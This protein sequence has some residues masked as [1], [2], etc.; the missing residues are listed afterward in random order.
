MVKFV[1]EDIGVAEAH[2]PPIVTKRAE[3][4]GLK[5]SWS[6]DLT[7]TDSDGK[8]WNFS[9]SLMRNRAINKINTDKPLLIIGGPM[10]KGW[11][12]MMSINWS[13]MTA[14]KQKHV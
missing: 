1:P 13:N 3:Q 4:W 6:P 2:S 9:S 14:E 10:C 11:S 12:T 7:A 5:G 8:A